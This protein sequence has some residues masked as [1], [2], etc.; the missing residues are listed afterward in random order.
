[1]LEFCDLLK[2]Y[3]GITEG[4]KLRNLLDLPFILK[5]REKKEHQR[6]EES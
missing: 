4:Q 2:F 5:M 1:M 3:R 6:S